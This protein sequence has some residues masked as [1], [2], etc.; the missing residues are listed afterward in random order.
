M[1]F[2]SAK[3]RAENVEAIIAKKLA[4]LATIGTFLANICQLPRDLF[5]GSWVLANFFLTV[6]LTNPPPPGRRRGGQRLPLSLG[7]NF[8]F[9]HS[10]SHPFPQLLSLAIIAP[11]TS[12]RNPEGAKIPGE[13]DSWDFGSGA[14]FY[15]DAT[16]DPWRQQYNMYSHPPAAYPGAQIFFHWCWCFGTGEQSPPPPMGQGIAFVSV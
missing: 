1:V 11:D 7:V 12:P 4:T 13:D 3:C 6:C 10:L 5:G 14:G 2:G 16:Q 9:D 8:N 15:V